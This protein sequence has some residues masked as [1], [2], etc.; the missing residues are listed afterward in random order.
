MIKVY[1]P[2]DS[3]VAQL[4]ALARRQSAVAETINATG[5]APKTDGTDCLLDKG[6]A[7]HGVRSWRMD[8]VR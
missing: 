3:E 8:G 2:G 7:R 1:A 5:V 6:G 4:V